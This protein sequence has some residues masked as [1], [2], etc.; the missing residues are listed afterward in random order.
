MTTWSQ[1]GCKECGERP[2]KVHL[3]L[4]HQWEH[5]HWQVVVLVPA[6]VP[7]SIHTHPPSTDRR[8]FVCHAQWFPSP[9]QFPFPHDTHTIGCLYCRKQCRLC[10]PTLLLR[11][12]NRFFHN[13]YWNPWRFK[14]SMGMCC[15]G[16]TAQRYKIS[17]GI[18]KSKA[19]LQFLPPSSPQLGLSL[20]VKGCF[21]LMCITISDLHHLQCAGGWNV[22]QWGK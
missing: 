4:S 11:G 21:F 9:P 1:T 12:W 16:V 10:P 13:L 7:A 20:H 5:R 18:S 22:I 19:P 6:L 15:G 17:Y 2:F 3:G 14:P 8:P